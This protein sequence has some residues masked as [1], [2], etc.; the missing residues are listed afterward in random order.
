MRAR[1]GT[2]LSPGFARLKQTTYGLGAQWENG[3]PYSP[4]LYTG[5]LGATLISRRSRIYTSRASNPAKR[6]N[7]TLVAPTRADSTPARHVPV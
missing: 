5:F 6:S 7:V 4:I 2:T 1:F 3:T